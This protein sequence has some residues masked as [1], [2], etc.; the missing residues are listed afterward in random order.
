MV[1]RRHRQNRHLIVAAFA[2]LAAACSAPTPK[3]DAGTERFSLWVLGAGQDGGLP[4]LGCNLECCRAA[5][6]GGLR[7]RPA[8]LGI[9]D[10]ESNRLVLIE[11]TP[12]IESQISDLHELAG[13]TRGKKR[14]VDAV[15][16]TH[17]HI[18]HYTGLIHFGRE[19]AGSKEIPVWATPRM[20]GFL[21]KNGPWKQ[22]VDLKQIELKPI[23]FDATFRPSP[24]LTV[25]A[26]QVPHRDEYSDTVAFKIRGPNRCV[27]FVP[28]TDSWTKHPGLLARLLADVDVAYFDGT[29][30]DGREL[31]DRN[32]DEIP[33]P[34]IVQTM[35]LLAEEAKEKPGALRF[36]HLNHTNPVLRDAE[37]RREVVRRG[38]RI[39]VEGERVGL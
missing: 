35:Q 11:A 37:L 33:H 17:A 30:Y 13:V 3:E 20:S 39:A 26:I 38:F 31:P 19:V 22:L 29:F 6:N 16:L 36:I 21:A 27:L 4:H 34:P 24:G 12:A 15:L 5:R 14:P 18:G 1:E 28:D 32:I 8:C 9:H 25:Q 2:L 10:R 23:A 7:L